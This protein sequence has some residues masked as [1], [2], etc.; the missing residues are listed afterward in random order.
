[1][2]IHVLMLCEMTTHNSLLNIMINENKVCISV[3]YKIK[4]LMLL[5]YEM[6]CICDH[7]H[8]YFKLL[9]NHLIFS[10]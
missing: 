9:Y 5:V 4:L 1:M 7:E 8:S 10:F 2:R 6:L 3:A